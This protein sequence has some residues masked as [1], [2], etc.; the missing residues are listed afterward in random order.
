MVN[1]LAFDFGGTNVKYGLADTQGHILNKAS[2]QTPPSLEGLLIFIKKQVLK[3]ADQRI[4]GIAISAPG[5]V[6]KKGVI[7]GSSAIPYIHGPNIKYHI[8]K[9]TGIRTEIENDANCAGLAEVWQGSGKGKKDVAIVVIGTGIGGSL[10]KDGAVHKGNTL[11]GGEFGYMILNPHNLGSGMNTFSETASTYSILKRVAAEKK[12]DVSTLTGEIV[13]SLA[14]QGDEVCKRA[15]SEFITMLSI[16]LYNIQYAYDPELILIGGGIS[17]RDDLISRLKTEIGRIV[18]TVEA[19]T[20][21]PEVDRCAFH[22]DANLVG[23]VYHFLQMR[24]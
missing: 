8:E 22:A 20:I 24:S 6:S 16:G 7:Y 9:E 12:I 1:V 4:E 19:A 18:G 3:Y 21:T 11:H 23:A 2:I 13:F 14:D 5:A 17:Q 15:I 10:I